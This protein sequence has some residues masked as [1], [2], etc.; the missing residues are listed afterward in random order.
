MNMHMHTPMRV[1]QGWDTHLL[2]PGRRLVLGGVDIAH[3]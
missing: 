3:H 1:G 2:V